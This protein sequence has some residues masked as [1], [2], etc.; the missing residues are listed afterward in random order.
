MITNFLKIERQEIVEQINNIL[1]EKDAWKDVYDSSTGQMFVQ[2]GAIPGEIVLYYI[3][4]AKQETYIS[5]AKLKSSI[6]NLAKLLNY[7][8]RRNTSAIGMVRFSIENPISNTI[9]IPAKTIVQSGNG[10]RYVTTM[11]AAIAAGSLFVD[12]EVRQGVW[13]TFEFSGNGMA[14]QSFTIDD[15]TIENNNVVVKVNGDTWNPVTSFVESV[16]SSLDYVLTNNLDDTVRLDFGDGVNG[17]IPENGAI[18]VVEY[19]QSIGANGNVDSL[20]YIDA[21]VSEI[22][23]VGGN[24][25]DVSVEN[26]TKILG[27][28]NIEGKEEIRFNAPKVFKTGDRAVTVEDHISI[29]ND[30]PGI[31]SSK[32]WGEREMNPP[33]IAMK[34]IVNLSILLENW[35]L[36]DNNFKDFVANFLYDNKSMLT[37]T[38]M[39]EDPLFVDVIVIDHIKVNQAYGISDVKTRAEQKIDEV[40]AL[41]TVYDDDG[42]IIGGVNIGEAVRYSNI[43]RQLDLIDGVEH[44]SLALNGYQLI[45]VGDDIET[46]FSDTLVLANPQP[47]TV[48][49]LIGGVVVAADDG[50][51][52]L[53]E[54]SSSGVSGTIGYTTGIIDVVADVAPEV[55]A[56]IRVQYKPRYSDVYPNDLVVGFNQIIKLNRKTVTAS[57]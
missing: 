55:G 57:Y 53:V 37:V 34:D 20:G 17:Y 8:P 19:L 25:V 5:T 35:A 27:G 6:V 24:A 38:Y 4:R 50:D 2:I 29:L 22:K 28:E 41:G 43:D 49:V 40:F 21:V 30:F 36:P 16:S 11:D 14:N 51:G 13:T 9:I 52:N 10:I 31:V 39:F 18:G 7:V 42:T 45:G 23:D 46:T 1:K 33:N 56:E 48:M 47:S 15:T 26:I 44:H 54:V 12:V 32:V 3:Q